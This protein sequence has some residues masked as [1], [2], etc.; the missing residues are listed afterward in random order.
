M[1]Q[2]IAPTRSVDLITAEVADEIWGEKLYQQRARKA[3]PILVRQAF[4]RKRIYYSDLSKEV[5][6]SNPRNCNYI[7]G[8]IGKTLKLLSSKNDI[9]IPAI[10]CLAINQNSKMPSDG[11]GWFISKQ[12]FKGLSRKQKEDLIDKKC[13]EIYS[14]PHWMDVLEQLGLEGPPKP[15]VILPNGTPMGGEGEDHKRLKDFVA[16][17]PQIVGLPKSCQAGVKELPLPSGDFVDVGFLWRRRHVLVEVK[18]E[19]SSAGEIL[20]GMYQCIKYESVKEAEL[21]VAVEPI[22]VRTI[23]VLGGR[24]P[25]ELIALKNTL[26]IEVLDNIKPS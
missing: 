15:P 22:D 5:G 2:G 24:L 21:A 11:V 3:L 1:T 16:R 18:P 23:L 8:C 6:F 14:F 10:Q 9:E 12:D 7:L 25:S 4:A 20:R 17:N 19:G 13:A 26:G